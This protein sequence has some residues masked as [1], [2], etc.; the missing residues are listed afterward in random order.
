VGRQRGPTGVS[1]RRLSWKTLSGYLGS[2]LIVVGVA[3]SSGCCTFSCPA[4]T[5]RSCSCLRAGERAALGL[6]ESIYAAILSILVYDFLF[7]NRC[8]PSSSP[9]RR[10]ADAVGFPGGRV[11]TGNLMLRIR[12]TRRTWRRRVCSQRPND[13]GPP[14][15]VHFA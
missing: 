4:R 10:T 13:C 12:R 7:V 11:L 6:G 2:T 15:V 9:A 1:P 14:A 5:S 3:A 8:T